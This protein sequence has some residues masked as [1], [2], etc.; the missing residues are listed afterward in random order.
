AGVVDGYLYGRGSADMKAA[1]AAQVFAAG[2][3]K[4]AGVKPAG[5][6]HVAAVVNE[7]RAEGVAMRRVVEDL[8]I[9]P[10]VVVLGEPTGLR[11]A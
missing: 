9:R 2:A 5:D 7:E 11:L 8:R 10:D 6:V 4:E 3:L 1:V